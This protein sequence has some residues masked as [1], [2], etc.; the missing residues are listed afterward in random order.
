MENYQ[1]KLVKFKEALAKIAMSNLI[2]HGDRILA[3]RLLTEALVESLNVERASIWL[4]DE[5]KTY[6]ELCDLFEVTSKT[7][8]AGMKLNQVDF[9]IYFSFLQ[10]NRVLVVEDAHADKITSEFSTSYLTPLNIH[11]MLDVPIR[12]GGEVVGVI[13][14][15]QVGRMRQWTIEDDFFVCA[16]ADIVG[17]VL[18]AE[19]R[20]HA[21]RQLQTQQMQSVQAAKL[22]SLGE[23]AGGV[24]HEINN[25]LQVI[26]S[27]SEFLKDLMMDQ[28]LDRESLK[29]SVHMIANTAQ[30]IDKI[31]KG[32][33][34]FAR[35][36]SIEQ[37]QLH[38][39]SNLFE[40]TLSFCRERFASRGVRL[41][42][43]EIREPIFLKINAI[44]VSQVLLNLLNN[45]FDAVVGKQGAWVRLDLDVF[46][47]MISISVTDSGEGIDPALRD[48]IMNPFF[49]TKPI[50]I[51]TGLGLSVSRGLV[52]SHGGRLYL[53]PTSKNTRFVVELPRTYEDVM[54]L[55]S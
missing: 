12:L 17:R 9:P 35:E 52:E 39:L 4:Y 31:V 54:A 27:A 50:G 26:L 32:L 45:A 51:G 11:S 15:E 20:L 34:Y 40:D 28:T 36:G 6:I 41:D 5:G 46:E 37:R 14:N 23:M 1:I 8:S 42:V 24:A 18:E 43:P 16:I 22:A 19:K 44:A 21:Q 53:E 7:H 13:C 3:F 49:T 48:K 38:S 25:P 30:R 2:D 10:Q 47:G 33:K 29:E 55:I